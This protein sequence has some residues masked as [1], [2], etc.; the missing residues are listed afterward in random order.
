MQ[1]CGLENE[2]AVFYVDQVWINYFPDF[3][4][5]CEA[6]LEDSFFGN[7]NLF[8]EDLETIANSLKGAAQLEGYQDSLVSFF[9]NRK[10][11]SFYCYCKD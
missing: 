1:T 9:L 11:I 10:L 6:I 2:V 4:K 8:G 3:L 7:E 5:S